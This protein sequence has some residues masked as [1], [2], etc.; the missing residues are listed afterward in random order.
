VALIQNLDVVI[1]TIGCVEI[2]RASIDVF[3]G[4]VFLVAVA[5]RLIALLVVL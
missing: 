2:Y 5:T 4:L 1:G 3:V